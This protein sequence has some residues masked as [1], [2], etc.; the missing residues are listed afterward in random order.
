MTTE[1][2][3]L[4]I[5]KLIMIIVGRRDCADTKEELRKVS[6]TAGCQLTRN[7]AEHAKTIVD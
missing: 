6:K 4:R 5:L 1:Y 3:I 7:G 2:T